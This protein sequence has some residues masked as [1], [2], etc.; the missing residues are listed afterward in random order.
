MTLNT[1]SKKRL[2]AVAFLI[3]FPVLSPISPIRAQEIE[4]IFREVSDDTIFYS[5]SHHGRWGYDLFTP[6]EIWCY[7]T[8]GGSHS[9]TQLIQL[10]R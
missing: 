3:V 6:S 9:H 4:I 8:R 1:G 2:K 5:F 7:A 10:P